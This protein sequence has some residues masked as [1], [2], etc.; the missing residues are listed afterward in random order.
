LIVIFCVGCGNSN[1]SK[2]E[3][4]TLLIKENTSSSMADSPITTRNLD[5]YLF[6]DNV[7]YIDVRP[8]EWV[9][10]DGYIANFKFIPF[11][12]II[13]KNASALDF[14]SVLFSY[15]YIKNEDGTEI[16]GGDV[17]SFSPIYEESI[18]IIKQLFPINQKILFIS[19]AGVESGYIINLLIQLGY[20]GKNLYNVGGFS[21]SD[22]TYIAYKNM[23]NPGPKYCVEGNP[24]IDI[25]INLSIN[26][27]LT[28]IS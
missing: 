7:S 1:S 24:Y 16:R 22:G 25:E 6:L 12:E 8:Y 4:R 5:E 9:I 18:Q 23:K 15:N 27:K 2:Q 13:A 3:E 26:E 14:K 21:N 11:Y 20:D 17:G 19:Q 28:K 10:S